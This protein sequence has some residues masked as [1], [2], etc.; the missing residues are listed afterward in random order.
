ML[1]EVSGDILLTKAKALAH[2]VAPNDNFA[3]GLDRKSTRLNSSHG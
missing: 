1:K 3:N 2:G